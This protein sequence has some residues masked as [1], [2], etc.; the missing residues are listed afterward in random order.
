M[1]ELEIELELECL[2]ADALHLGHRAAGRI[3]NRDR[4]LGW[5]LDPDAADRNP[6]LRRDTGT[7]FCWHG[8]PNCTKR[9]G[10]GAWEE[11]LGDVAG[12]PLRHGFRGVTD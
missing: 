3:D 6:K 4:I 11:L 12:R 9:V 8:I 7:E 1:S 2:A 5:V 10:N